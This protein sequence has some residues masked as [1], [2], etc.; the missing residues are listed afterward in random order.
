MKYTIRKLLFLLSLVSI[1]GAP[2]AYAEY[3][4]ITT[5]DPYILIAREVENYVKGGVDVLNVSDN[6]DR[7]DGIRMILYIQDF[8]NWSLRKDQQNLNQ[9]AIQ[10][11]GRY[12]FTSVA[13]FIGWDFEPDNFKVQGSWICPEPRRQ[14]CEWLTVPGIAV[15]KEFIIWPGIGNP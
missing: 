8:P 13:M 11:V 7:P 14:S 15:G 4:S 9:L 3:Q 12:D 2:F 5:V 10:A 1:V 6:P